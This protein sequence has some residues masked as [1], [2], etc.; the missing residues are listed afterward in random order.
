MD[1][2]WGRVGK[3]KGCS[4]E[5]NLRIDMQPK[6]RLFLKNKYFLDENMFLKKLWKVYKNVLLISLK[7]WPKNHFDQ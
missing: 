6:G 7:R 5:R 4:S 2:V 1:G 3:G